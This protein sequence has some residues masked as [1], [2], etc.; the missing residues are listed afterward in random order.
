MEVYRTLAWYSFVMSDDVAPVPPTS[1]T[2]RRPPENAARAYVRASKSE[3][4][5]RACRA[6]LQDFESW[7]AEQAVSPL[8]PCRRPSRYIPADWPSWERKPSPSSANSPPKRGSYA[9]LA[10]LRKYAMRGWL[11]A[12][13]GSG[14]NIRGKS[15]RGRS[16]HSRQSG[17]E[18]ALAPMTGSIGTEV[19]CRR[20]G[21]AAS[22]STADPGRGCRRPVIPA[23]EPHP[24]TASA[25]QKG[26]EYTWNR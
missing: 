12:A 26:T 9:S 15:R 11:S 24:R 23:A 5:L 18:R 13:Q 3:N 6:D 25:H 1:L 7:C 10:G 20:T 4:T 14:E 2:L 19:M 22:D 8:P 16:S 21:R 17:E